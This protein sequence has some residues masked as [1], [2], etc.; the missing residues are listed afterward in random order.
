MRVHIYELSD[1]PTSLSFTENDEWLVTAIKSVEES[2]ISS[3]KPHYKV[4]FS[5][6]KSQELVFLNGKLEVERGALCSR[7]ATDIVVPLHSKFENLFTKQADM[8]NPSDAHS[9][10]VAYSAPTGATGEEM[11]I[12][13]LEKD[14]I[15]LEEVLKEQL[16]L[17]LPFQPLCKEDCKGICPTCGQ[18]QNTHPCQCHRIRNTSLANALRQRFGLK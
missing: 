12:E 7:C 16:Y 4:D 3:K 17:R 18:D 5:I 8:E 15:E 10:G 13:R 6:Y 9:H 2:E 1:E 14:Y 11:E